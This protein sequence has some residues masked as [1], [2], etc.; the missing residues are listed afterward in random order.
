MGLLLLL[1][2]IAGDRITAAVDG[3]IKGDRDPLLFAGCAS[4]NN[5][6]NIRI[7]SPNSLVITFEIAF[8]CDLV[9][10]S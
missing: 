7:V 8:L 6:G 3:R 2:D 10:N 1:D 9:N 4:S 5:L